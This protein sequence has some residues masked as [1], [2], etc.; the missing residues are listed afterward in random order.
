MKRYRIYK[1]EDL[2]PV[3][4]EVHGF[5]KEQLE[6]KLRTRELVRCRQIMMYI[7]YIYLKQLSL[8]AIGSRFGGRD[9]S[10]VIHSRTIIQNALT[11]P[12]ADSATY[13]M[14]KAVFDKCWMMPKTKEVRRVELSIFG[15]SSIIRKYNTL[16]GSHV[17]RLRVLNDCYLESI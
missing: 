7:E 8:K 9:H 1:L 5:T 13:E 6:G 12:R 10:T 15:I 14:F 16:E 4:L 2:F 11:N 17:E 3:I